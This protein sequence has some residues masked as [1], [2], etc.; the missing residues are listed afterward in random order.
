MSEGSFTSGGPQFG[1]IALDASGNIYLTGG[2]LSSGLPAVNPEMPKRGSRRN[3]FVTKFDPT[4]KPL[5]TSY[6][7]GTVLRSSQTGD[8]GGDYPLAIA[9]DPAGEVVVVGRTFS[10]DFPVVNAFQGV[11]QATTFFSADGFVA[12]LSSDGKR[13][14]YSSYFGGRDGNS[15]LSG[16]VAGP[17][18]EVWI[19]GSSTSNQ[20]ATQYNVSNPDSNGVFVL[21]LNPAG[22]VIWSTR[23]SGGNVY[24]LAVDALGQPHIAADCRLASGSC[25]TFVAKLS[26]GGSQ[27]LYRERVS[28]GN[29]RVRLS[30]SP[31][32]QVA[33]AGTQGSTQP[34]DA[35]PVSWGLGG[36]GFVRTLDSAGQTLFSN[37]VNASQDLADVQVLWSDRLLV[38]FHTAAVALPTERALVAV[39]PDG[40][41]YVSDD[42]AANWVSIGG[43]ASSA[44][45][46]I[47][48]TRDQVF[49]AG[50]RSDDQGRSWVTDGGAGAPTFAVDPRRQ[51]IQWLAGAE[52]RGPIRRRVDG[53]PWQLVGPATGPEAVSIKTAT[54]A[55]SPHDGAAWVGGEFGVEIIKEDGSYRYENDGLPAPLTRATKGYAEVHA[56]AFDPN[57]PEVV[58]AATLAGLYGRFGAGTGWVPLTSQIPAQDNLLSRYVL[59]AAVDP[60][61]SNVVL[62]GHVSDGLYR[63]IDRAR[64]WQRVIPGTGIRNIV[65][66]PNRPGVVYATGD[67]IYRS[68]DHGATWQRTS[69][70]YESRYA[71]SA[72]AIN[73]KTSRLYISSELIK[74]IA[75]V[76][77]VTGFGATATR[78]WAT[79]LKD[80]VVFDLARTPA[81]DAVV[82]LKDVGTQ[83]TAVTIVRIAR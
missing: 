56:F 71:P 78:S 19:A 81:G 39:H 59:T 14:L 68:L 77:D 80:G 25:S 23:M 13:L 8:P 24:D 26:S 28:S 69:M 58:Y 11:P 67:A 74:P 35:W 17:G 43:P 5:W 34:A 50:T 65:F 51:N 2:T 48:S 46:Q 4:G 12:K 70:G 16:V 64:N 72:M 20:I 15:S 79:Y 49:A 38:A 42:G 55:V 37:A 40:P 32:G 60:Q 45:I 82:A 61:N 27:Q 7:G 10:T 22:G 73:A 41:L 36:F 9:V 1:G 6:F 31:A 44:A 66:D 47:D 75:F 54:L 21:K 3:I 29:A 83:E 18:G 57:D 76:M 33:V 62:I 30:L 52:N 53:G 63:S